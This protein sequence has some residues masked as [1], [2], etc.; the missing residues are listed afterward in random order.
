[1]P[2]NALQNKSALKNNRPEGEISPLS[3]KRPSK[4]GLALQKNED[5]FPGYKNKVFL[6][7]I[8][9][10]KMY[11]PGFEESSLKMKLGERSIQ[12][13]CCTRAHCYAVT[14]TDSFSL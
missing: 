9:L 13:I 3:K 14:V 11:H 4:S 10:L 5:S 1:M 7:C 2:L 8:F 12:Q 6:V